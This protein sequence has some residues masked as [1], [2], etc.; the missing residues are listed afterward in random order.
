MTNY[1]SNFSSAD[2]EEE[3]YFVDSGEDMTEI[4]LYDFNKK[5]EYHQKDYYNCICIRVTRSCVLDTLYD[6]VIIDSMIPVTVSLPNFINISTQDNTP[7]STK[8]IVIK[9]VR[10]S[11]YHT[12]KCNDGTKFMNGQSMLTIQSF[13][14]ID[15][16]LYDNVWYVI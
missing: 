10:C 12:I 8:R 2:A 5:K 13:E 4:E 3:S 11:A 1:R 7:Q 14:Y 15:V 9:S 16:V 6:V